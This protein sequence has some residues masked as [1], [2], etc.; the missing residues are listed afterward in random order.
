MANET[1]NKLIDAGI[2]FP[3]ADDLVK[4]GAHFGHR[5]TKW[6]PKM[7]SYIFG[8]KNDVHIFD[9]EKTL[10]YLKKAMDFVRETASRDGTILLV[11]TTPAAK[12]VVIQAADDSQMPFVAERWLGGTLTNFKILAKRLHHFRDLEKKRDA[13]ELQKYTKK[14]QNEFNEELKKLEKKFG[15]I[16]HLS[17][18]PDALFILDPRKN[19]AA[20]REANISKVPVIALCDSNID[21]TGVNYPIPA[22]DDAISSL[23]IITSCVVKAI[24]EGKKQIVKTDL[25][26][27]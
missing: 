2:K 12:K 14:E 10:E 26:E 4:A 23:A 1:E 13:G 17:K 11:G 19:F 18:L 6:N 21:P 16:K 9:V 7:E 3:T 20:V 25:A 22:N 27:K 5:T 24:N 15:G 8:A